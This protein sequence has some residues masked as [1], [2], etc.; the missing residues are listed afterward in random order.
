PSVCTPL[1]CC[2]ASDIRWMEFSSK[3]GLRLRDPI[4]N[5]EPW[6]SS[7][8]LPTYGTDAERVR[9]KPCTCLD[10]IGHCP[11]SKG[12]LGSRSCG[13]NVPSQFKRQCWGCQCILPANASRSCRRTSTAHGLQSVALDGQDVVPCKRRTKLLRTE[14]SARTTFG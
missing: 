9:T 10:E 12:M 14:P 4:M 3:N 8:K 5:T 6:V 7:L 2:S 11:S 1:G 13:G